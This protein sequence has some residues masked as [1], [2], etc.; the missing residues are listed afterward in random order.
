M[1]YF[2]RWED[3]EG[4]LRE[5]QALLA[6]KVRD[7]PCRPSSDLAKPNKP[8]SDF[9]LFAHASGQWAKKILGK[10][11]YFGTWDDPAG[12]LARYN[13]LREGRDGGNEPPR[14]AKPDRSERLAKRSKPYA[15]FPLFPHASG[16]WAKKIRGQMHYFGTWDDWRAALD[17]YE[18]QKDALHSGRTPRPDPATLIVKDVANDFLKAKEEAMKAGELSQRTWLDYRS[19]IEMLL[20][21]IGPRRSVADLEPQDFAALKSKLAK[22]NGPHRMCTIIQVIRCAFKYAF[23]SGTLDRP[24]RFGPAFKRTSKKTLRL[25]RAKQGAKLFTA[26]EVRRMIDA[27]GPTMRAMIFLGINAGFGNADCGTLPLS[28][29][30]LEKGII[31]YARPKTG[32]P[33]RCA[34]WPET[35][36]AMRKAMEKRPAPKREEGAGLVFLTKYGYGWNKDVNAGPVTQ[37]MRKLLKKLGINGHRN[38]Y[39]L[40]HTFRTIADEI[41]DQPAVDFV[42]GHEVPHMSAVYR[43]T[44]SDARLRAVVDHVRDWLFPSSVF[45]KSIE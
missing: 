27:A 18:R 2:G 20:R 26:E 10:M 4:A 11:Y 19:I 38:F 15:D 25:H 5:Y 6:G 14:R 32:I 31:D 39:T 8:S 42:M 3:P 37:E 22:R 12:A 29:V 36:E 45:V 41:K 1:Y 35:I 24:I 40:R 17:N 13:Q 44:I 7:K 21:G 16:Q 28:A 9:P 43:E 30:D 34:L 33:R 23:D